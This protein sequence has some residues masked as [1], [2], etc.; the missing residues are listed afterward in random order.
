M[1]VDFKIIS[2]KITRHIPSENM[3]RNSGFSF[4]SFEYFHKFQETNKLWIISV[5]VGY[6]PV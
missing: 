4:L 6:G 2:N 1:L 3:F 5:R